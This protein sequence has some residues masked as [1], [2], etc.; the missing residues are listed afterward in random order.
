MNEVYTFRY[1]D[2]QSRMQR[3]IN[4]IFIYIKRILYI[5]INMK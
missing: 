2:S 1:E 4:Q 3:K 5:F